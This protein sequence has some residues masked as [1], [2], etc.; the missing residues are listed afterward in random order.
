MVSVGIERYEYGHEMVR[1]Q[2]ACVG[3]TSGVVLVGY[4]YGCEVV[5]GKR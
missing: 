1:R 4:M 2:R 5:M 3:W